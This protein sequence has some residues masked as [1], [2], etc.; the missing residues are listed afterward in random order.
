MIFY[1]GSYST[2]AGKEYLIGYEEGKQNTGDV[3]VK[4]IK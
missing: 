3:I 1:Y 2:T 4:E